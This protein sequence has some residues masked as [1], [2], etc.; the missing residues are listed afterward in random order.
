MYTRTYTHPLSNHMKDRIKTCQ[1]WMNERRVFFFIGHR[2]GMSWYQGCSKVNPSYAEWQPY[3]DHRIGLRKNEGQWGAGWIT[4]LSYILPPHT[5]VCAGRV[6]EGKP[7]RCH[8]Y[9]YY[10]RVQWVI[11]GIPRA[12]IS[13]VFFEIRRNKRTSK[14]G[15][16]HKLNCI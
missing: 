11:M 9:T 10:M 12:L 4:N 1:A 13:T 15:L 6:V 16:C 14:C 3:S 7:K 5:S 8:A 2:I